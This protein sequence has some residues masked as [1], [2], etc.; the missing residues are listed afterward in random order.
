MPSDDA[1]EFFAQKLGVDLEEL[2]TGRP[3][4]AAKELR[5]KAEKA[6]VSISDGQIETA[7]RSVKEVIKQAREFHV[8][9]V[10]AR[11]H[12]VLALA[13][14]RSGDLDGAVKSY[15]KVLEL[16]REE[17]SLDAKSE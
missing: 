17:A 2:A 12:E 4:G 3:A 8:P 10:E 7:K 16:L 5:L 13:R 14:E 11:G 1:L 9:R 15:G 6:R